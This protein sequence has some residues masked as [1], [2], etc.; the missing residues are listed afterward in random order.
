MYICLLYDRAMKIRWNELGIPEVMVIAMNPIAMICRNITIPV[1][2]NITVSP[3][4]TKSL[5]QYLFYSSN[6]NWKKWV[7]RHYIGTQIDWT[8]S[9]NALWRIEK[10]VSNK[11]QFWNVSLSNFVW[12]KPRHI[13]IWNLPWHFCSYY[14]CFHNWCERRY[15]LY[16]G[17]T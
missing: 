14:K 3:T 17:H 2:S 5:L 8:I 16:H 9:S 13:Q 1:W 7:N 11:Q 12:Y 15:I 6:I 10:C 4:Y